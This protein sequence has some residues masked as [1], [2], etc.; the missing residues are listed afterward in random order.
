MHA[1]GK[2]APKSRHRRSTPD[3]G[4]AILSRTIEDECRHLHARY[5]G[6]Q[7]QLREAMDTARRDVPVRLT[8]V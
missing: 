6:S 3:A 7:L 2:S 8:V 5:V 1:S 4:L